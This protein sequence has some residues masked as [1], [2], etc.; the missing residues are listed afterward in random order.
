MI[1]VIIPLYN[2]EA[3]VEQ[4][5]RSVLSQSFRDFEVVVVD[6][7]STD[8]S[9][10]IVR[11]INDPRLHL[12]S[13]ENGGPSK[14]RNTGVR[15]GK[16]EWIL[17]LDAD[18]ELLPDALKHFHQLAEEHPEID[19]FLGEVLMNDGQSKR[20]ATQYQEGEIRNIFRAHALGL[21]MQCSGS[22][23][24]RRTLCER[25][26]LDERIR[27]Y[28]DLECL[29]RK[30]K[31]GRLWLTH[32]P[33]AMVNCEFAAASRGRKDIKEDFMGYLD[34]HGKGFWER[35]SLYGFFLGE[36][37]HYDRQARAIYPPLYRNYGMLLVYKLFSWLRRCK[38]LW[39]AY[40]RLFC[41]YTI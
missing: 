3:I 35:F 28:E 34:F 39:R 36:R 25:H 37:E 9:A 27:R 5:L 20:L 13:Q 19:M 10:E 15:E 11:C 23:M 18:D 14:A 26:P 38:P 2:K 12:V 29:F 6:D 40:L 8:R 1:S 41:Q 30:Y 16:G 33:V 31:D 22:T 4:S 7:G 24:Y 32:Q 21:L 17:F